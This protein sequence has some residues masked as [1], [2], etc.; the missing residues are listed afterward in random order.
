LLFAV[1]LAYVGA[2][3][4]AAAFFVSPVR[5]VQ[6]Y[7]PSMNGI[8]QEDFEV[9]TQ[10]GVP[11]RGW[12]VE[13]TE[14][15]I[16]VFTHGYMMNRCEFAPYAQ[17]FHELGVGSVYFDTRGHGRSGGKRVGI[18]FTEQADVT[19]VLGHLRTRFPA[20]KFVLVG[21]SM[22]SVASIYTALC[23]PEDV[24][25]LVL[26]APYPTLHEAVDG[27]WSFCGYPHLAPFLAP[28]APIG[29]RMAGIP[30]RSVRPIDEVGKLQ[31]LSVLLLTGT[32]DPI[33]KPERIH[34]M[35]R[36]IGPTAKVHV[37]EDCTHGQ[38]RA[39]YAHEFRFLL[40]DFI[41]SL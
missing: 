8:P 31:G 21:S 5:I 4:G 18:G 9:I 12:T 38:I 28:I 26:D 19:A 29:S 10:D 6:W 37:F 35:A 13:G 30:L 17:M 40:Q 14:H 1:A 32:R 24:V 22:G 34:E 36:R 7:S 33:A 23:R 2:I 16:L 20:K 27:W 25:G 11:I 15:I 41:K 3:V 39:K